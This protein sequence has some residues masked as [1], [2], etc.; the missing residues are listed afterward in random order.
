MQWRLADDS[1][2]AAGRMPWSGLLDAHSGDG[3][4]NHQLLDLLGAFE[5]VHDPRILSHLSH[6]P[7]IV[8]FTRVLWC[9]R[10]VCG[11]ARAPIVGIC[12]GIPAAGEA[13]DG[14][15][16]SPSAASCPQTWRDDPGTPSPEP[17]V[18]QGRP[19][20]STMRQCN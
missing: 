5:D 17:L 18:A 13:P 14:G 3:S 2:R 19:G 4:A 1:S 15:S 6:R 10:A 20:P 11:T 7:V 16:R 8:G 12:V 9:L